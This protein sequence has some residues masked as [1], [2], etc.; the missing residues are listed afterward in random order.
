[1]REVSTLITVNIDGVPVAASSVSAFR[2]AVGEGEFVLEH[3]SVEM[4]QANR[5]PALTTFLFYPPRGTIAQ[6]VI[7]FDIGWTT[8]G[9][10]PLMIKGPIHFSGPG[11]FQATGICMTAN[12]RV[13]GIFAYRRVK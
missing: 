9:K 6:R 10:H 5:L 11:Y 1:M 8:E 2:H 3:A 12:D 4:N 13:T 7:A